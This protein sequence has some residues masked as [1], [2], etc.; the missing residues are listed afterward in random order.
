M[1]RKTFESLGKVL[2]NRHHVVLTK[3]RDFKVQDA[4]VQIINDVKDLDK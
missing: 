3:N 1:G 4:N 2:P